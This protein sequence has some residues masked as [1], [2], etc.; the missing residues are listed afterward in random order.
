MG[1]RDRKKQDEQVK[2]EITRIILFAHHAQIDLK[3]YMKFPLILYLSL[4][5]CD[6]KIIFILNFDSILLPNTQIWGLFRLKNTY[7]R[8]CLLVSL[9]EKRLLVLWTGLPSRP[10]IISSG[11]MTFNVSSANIKNND[12]KLLC[13]I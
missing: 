9:T 12:I 2:N 4:I 13:N 10:R 7:D 1:E 5:C 3:F 8:I 6:I 11:L